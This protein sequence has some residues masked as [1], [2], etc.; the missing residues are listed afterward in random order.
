MKSY[1]EEIEIYFELKGA[2]EST[3]ESYMR[4]IKAF[5]AFIQNSGKSIEDITERDIQQ[6]ILYLKNEKGLSAGTINNYS[7]AIRFFYTNVLDKVWNPQKL[8]RMK[9]RAHFPVIPPR[10]SYFC[11]YLA[12]LFCNSLPGK[13]RSTC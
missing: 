5:L 1:Q 10:S 4:R 12:S 11:P 6:Y 2:P 13:W 7:S 9:R 3:K 8:P